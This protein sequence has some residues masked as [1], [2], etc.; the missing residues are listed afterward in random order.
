MLSKMMGFS[1]FDSS[2]GRDHSEDLSR[3][4]QGA[5]QGVM[6]GVMCRHKRSQ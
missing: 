4:N 1:A 5:G 2:K 3:W 6:A